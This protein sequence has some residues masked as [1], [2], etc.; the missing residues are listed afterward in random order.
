MENKS[1]QIKA[2]LL[3]HMISNDNKKTSESSW[4]HSNDNFYSK[5]ENDTVSWD[6]EAYIKRL[7]KLFE[8]EKLLENLEI[9]KLDNPEIFEEN[10][11]EYLFKYKITIKNLKIECKSE[12]FTFDM[13]TIK[14]EYSKKNSKLMIDKYKGGIYICFENIVF[15]SFENYNSYIRVL[16]NK[17][18]RLIFKNCIFTGVDVFLK[19]K[20]NS[21]I[22]FYKN[23]FNN[24]HLT[25]NADVEHDDITG[26]KTGNNHIKIEN[27]SRIYASRQLNS[28]IRRSHKNDSLQFKEEILRKI[29]N[30]E[31]ITITDVVKYM[32]DK[33]YNL[34]VTPSDVEYS[35][36]TNTL[37]TLRDNIISEIKIS[38][39]SFYFLGVNKIE[40]ISPSSTP[41][42]IYWG[43][44]NELDKKGKNA[45]NH[46]FTFISWKEYALKGKDK[47]Q[48][49]ILNKELM[50]IERHILNKEN[51]NKS[52]KD[53][54]ILWFN[55]FSSDFGT[56]WIKPICLILI[57]NLL[58]IVILF[59]ELEYSFIF[60][61]AAF[62]DTFGLFIEF[63]VPI[64]SVEKILDVKELNRGWEALNIIKNILLSILLYQ[65]IVA[66][67]RFG[68]K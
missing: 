40:K 41:D 8:E 58:F 52:L 67:R 24:R 9:K 53:R 29:K 60:T 47:S 28:F 43:A 66:F 25:I 54:F 33:D 65:S 3:S 30:E 56:N 20:D 48:E 61:G 51:T 19:V 50:Q 11:S 46:K 57:I 16:L 63:L 45:R 27:L 55:S 23:E 64:Q 44:Y 4:R 36:K 15:K 1:K 62:F 18:G 14:D 10:N 39:K 5:C 38:G 37:I 49:L 35:N 7:K 21:S 26:F 12:L 32:I 31:D 34:S 17:E 22:Y 13:L 68:N 2:N 59:N 6:I 42:A